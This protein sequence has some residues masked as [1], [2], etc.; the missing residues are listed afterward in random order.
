MRADVTMLEEKKIDEDFSGFDDQSC[1]YCMKRITPAEQAAVKVQMFLMDGCYHQFHI[2]CFR[3]YA[4]KQ[5]LTKLPNGEFGECRCNKCKTLVTA[6]DLR[7]ALGV[8]ALQQIRDKQTQ[9]QLGDDIV[10]CPDPECAAVFQAV[11]DRP[12]YNA[13]DEEGKKVTRETAEHMAKYRLRCPGCTKNF[14]IGC[15]KQPYHI[16]MNC[17]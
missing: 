6:E 17:E 2:D 12:N 15:K 3:L 5:L 14:C 4:R 1:V 8:E 10:T 9:M 16:G 13:R 11:P 7:E